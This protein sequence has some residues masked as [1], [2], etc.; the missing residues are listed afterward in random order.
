MTPSQLDESANAPWT[1]TTVGFPGG[2]AA[3]AGAGISASNH[4]MKPSRK[5]ILRAA[6][7]GPGLAVAWL[8]EVSGDME[9][10][11]LDRSAWRTAAMAC[12]AMAACRQ[13]KRGR[14]RRFTLERGTTVRKHP[15]T[16]EKP[17]PWRHMP[18]GLVR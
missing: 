3:R 6:S 4:N 8:R 15:S 7:E 18:G 10:I 1:R 9:G 11:L 12:L 16:H 13:S 14:R 2:G 17:R 5:T